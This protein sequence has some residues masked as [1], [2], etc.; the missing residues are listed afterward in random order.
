M[1]HLITLL[2]HAVEAVG[3]RVGGFLSMATP[4]QRSFIPIPLQ[5]QRPNNDRR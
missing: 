5:A 1:K 4:E 2:M 3:H